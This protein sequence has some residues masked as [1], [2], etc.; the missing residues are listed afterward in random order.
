MRQVQ[1]QPGPRVESTGTKFSQVT[2][3]T[4]EDDESEK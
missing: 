3:I 2:Y 4:L 1:K